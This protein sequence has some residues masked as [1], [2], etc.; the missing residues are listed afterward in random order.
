MSNIIKMK[1][2]LN[3]LFTNLYF[4]KVFIVEEK[5]I[6]TKQISGIQS[7]VNFHVLPQPISG[8]EQ[9]ISKMTLFDSWKTFFLLLEDN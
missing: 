8:A 4:S 5:Y 7:V 6:S 1:S 3:N 2:F 9:K